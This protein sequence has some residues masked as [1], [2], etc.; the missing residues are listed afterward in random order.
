MSPVRAGC[1]LRIIAGS[2][3]QD[4][5]PRKAVVAFILTVVALAFVCLGLG[6]TKD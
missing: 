5:N 1:S 3:R 4:A 2:T 6:R